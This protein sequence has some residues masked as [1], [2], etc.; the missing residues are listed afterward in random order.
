[1]KTFRFLIAFLVV[2]LVASYNYTNA[3]SKDN[4]IALKVNLSEEV[5][6]MNPVWA[7]FGY[8]EPNYTYMKDGRKL[9]SEISALSNVPV[10]VRTHNLLTTGDGSA[11]LKWGSTNIYTEDK[12]GKPVYD[13]TIT[14]KIFDSYIERGMKPLV[15]MGFMPVALSTNPQPYRH[16]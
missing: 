4:T 5:G 6:P 3:Q 14:D 10:H 15:E 12:D 11:S 16:E 8:D 7:W 13:W 1:M 2:L 9:L